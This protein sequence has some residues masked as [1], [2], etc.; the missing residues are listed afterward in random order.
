L[1]YDETVSLVEAGYESGESAYCGVSNTVWYSFT[2]RSDAV[3]RVDSSG[4]SFFGAVFVAYRQ[5]GSG[6]GGLSQIACSSYGGPLLLDVESGT[7]YY[8]QAGSAYWGSG[9]LRVTIE[10]IPPPPN[11]DFADALPVSVPYSNAQSS[12]AATR[13]PGEPIGSCGQST[14]NSHWYAFTAPSGGSYTGPS[15]ACTWGTPSTR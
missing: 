8:I 7:T 6:I 9:D 1:P 2:S 14:T 4:S 5:N 3:V 15:S 10:E 12:L 13:E 11:D